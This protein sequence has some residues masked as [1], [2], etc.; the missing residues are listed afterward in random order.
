MSAEHNNWDKITKRVWASFHKQQTIAGHA[1]ALWGDIE[2][3]P[4]LYSIIF[5]CKEF[6]YTC[7]FGC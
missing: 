7:D 4:R 2:P 6:S 5:L 1:E 3:Y